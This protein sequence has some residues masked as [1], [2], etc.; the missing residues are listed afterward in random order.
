MMMVQHFYSETFKTREMKY[1]IIAFA[2]VFALKVNAQTGL[3]Y[4]KAG[5]AKD[6][7]GDYKGPSWNTIRPQ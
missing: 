1:I 2:L 4:L 7:L 3:D 6:Q 5:I